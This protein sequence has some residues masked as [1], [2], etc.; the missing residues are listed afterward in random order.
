MSDF[1]KDHDVS[2][3]PGYDLRM[4]YLEEREN[5]TVQPTKKHSDLIYAA[6]FLN[7]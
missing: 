5:N 1:M 7:V 3:T 4:N 2:I 6:M